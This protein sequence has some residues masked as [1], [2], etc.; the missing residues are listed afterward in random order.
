MRNL[1]S[2]MVF[3]LLA[4]CAP[5]SE[6][7]AGTSKIITISGENF[8]ID[9]EIKMSR[10]GYVEYKDAI[11]SSNTY[12][13]G[14]TDGENKRIIETV[15][16]SES[17]KK[18]SPEEYIIEKKILGVKLNSD[19]NKDIAKLLEGLSVVETV[20]SNG[21]VVDTHFYKN[22]SELDADSGL[23][24]YIKSFIQIEKRDKSLRVGDTL[25][26]I[27]GDFGEFTFDIKNRVAGF[28]YSESGEAVVIVEP[29]MSE[30]ML[31]SF[32]LKFNV[33]FIISGH[34]AVD[35]KTGL[36]LISNMTM[37]VERDDGSVSVIGSTSSMLSA[38]TR[39]KIKQ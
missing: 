4:V 9:P 11:S 5:L 34:S 10:L 14:R 12:T 30:Q 24:N 33:N 26:S 20:K 31:S 2:V 38:E 39:F 3:F 37:Q 22:G 35:L 27:T 19:P 23:F 16:Q 6:L 21:V 13:E 28:G 17:L 36:L 25:S 32:K 15:L 29:E 8:S 7:L 1:L 18:L